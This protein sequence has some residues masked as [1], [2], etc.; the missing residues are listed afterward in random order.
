MAKYLN[1]TGLQTFWNKIKNA[2]ATKAEKADSVYY[3][4][5]TTSYATYSAS[6]TYAVGA[7]CVYS[8][9]AY[10]CKTA[11]TTAEAWNSNHWTAIATPVWKGSI[12][13]LTALSAGL[14]IAYKLPI[15]GGSSST[16][17]NM[18]G[19][20]NKYVK[21]CTGST[22]TH[23]AAGTIVFLTYDGTQWVWAD[24]SVGDNYYCVPDAYCSTGADTA[25]KTATSIGFNLSYHA[26]IPFR[27]Y[28]TKSNSYSG[29]ITLNVN[30]T[31]AKN[32]YINGSNSSSSNKT[33]NV[34]VY[35]CYYDGTQYQLLT[36]NKAM[37]V[38]GGIRGN[39][40]G[41]CSGSSGSCTGN[42]ATATTAKDY[43]SSS[44]TIKTALNG[45]ADKKVPS[46][47]NNVALLDSNGN[48]VD[49]GKTLGKSVPSNAVFTDTTYT[50]GT[51]LNLSSGTFSVKYGTS[52]GTACQGNDSRLSDSR[53]PK[54]HTH[55]AEDITESVNAAKEIYKNDNGMAFH[56]NIASGN[57]YRFKMPSSSTDSAS[58]LFH[59]SGFDSS[60]NLYPIVFCISF[61]WSGSSWSQ[62]PK[63]AILYS[64]NLSTS[65]CKPIV[66]YSSG[67]YLYVRVAGSSSGNFRFF[68]SYSGCST[69]GWEYK[70]NLSTSDSGY[71][72]AT[73]VSGV[74]SCV[75]T[76]NI[77]SGVGSETTPVYQKTSGFLAACTS[78]NAVTWNG[79]K[80]NVGSVSSASNTISF[81]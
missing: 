27:I 43:D 35:W 6:S 2:L 70:N 76:S 29:Q 75:F 56:S 49:S 19:L 25:A 13:G 1:L 39:V 64:T 46:A 36:T 7:E 4:A 40:T 73:S 52:S 22:T 78:V 38:P 32:L 9:K 44:G 41:N 68:C 26:N 50:N 31:G 17:L 10:S 59:C 8:G 60:S 71:S 33:I 58:M 48:L 28:F 23:L 74:E 15:T 21:R 55:S 62:T 51:G 77:T 42:A 12:T 80:I 30:S 47:A 18:N 57:V 79:Y 20:G 69:S 45:K 61:N 3:V 14:K 81:L 34:G 11:I 66:K 5:G 24:Y 37:P 16:Y 63:L 67:G 72:N 65:S 53:T 54:A